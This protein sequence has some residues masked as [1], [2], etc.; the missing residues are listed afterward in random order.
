MNATA[1][2]GICLAALLL[3]AAGGQ[4]V[5]HNGGADY[6]NVET[7]LQTGE[8]VMGETIVYPQEAPA[9]VA[10]LIVTMAPGE[11]TGRHKHPVP[12][13]GYVLDGEITVVYEG[14]GPRT[15]AKGEAFM[16]AEDVWHNGYNSGAEPARVLVVF[17]GAEGL[18]NVVQPQ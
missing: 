11:E 10:S 2:T 15:Y 3:L 13:Y 14:R 1:K 7:L 8:T 4:P 6:Q 18:A 16:E 9:R 12:T 17:M 5:K